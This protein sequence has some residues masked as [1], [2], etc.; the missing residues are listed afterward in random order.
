MLMAMRYERTTWLLFIRDI[1]SQRFIHESHPTVRMASIFPSPIQPCFL[2][3]HQ[4]LAWQAFSAVR[5][6]YLAPIQSIAY[7][8]H[9]DLF[10]AGRSFLDSTSSPSYPLSPL[11]SIIIESLASLP[12]L[13][14]HS[15]IISLSRSCCL[16]FS[17]LFPAVRRGM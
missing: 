12:S 14:R 8:L 3:C 17:S 11:H 4:V 13:I 16:P 7:S 2:L 6:C 5:P 1:N 10:N 15:L 9:L